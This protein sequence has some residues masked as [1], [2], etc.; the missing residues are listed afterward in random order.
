MIRRTLGGA[1]LLVLVV[2]G[3]GYLYLLSSLPQLDGRV[4][5]TGLAGEVRIARDT[6]GVPLIAAGGDEDA[7]FGLGFAHA[8]DRLFQMEM[9]RRYGAG[10]LAEIFGPRALGV[11]RQMRVLGLYRAAEAGLP[12]LAPAVQRRFEAYAAGVN[13][14][15]AARRAALPPEFLL[16]RFRPEPWRPADS[17]V[18]DKLM[19]LELAGNYRGEL[20]RAR[21]ARTLSPD[22]LAFLYPEYP[23]DAPT[24]LAELT[25]L[26]RQLP[27]DRLYA[28][29]PAIVGLHYASNNWVVD[30]AHSDSGKPILA[31]DPHLG[32]RAPSVWYLA[33]LEAPG[34]S[35]AGATL[36]GIPSVIIGHNDRIAWGLTSLEPDVQDLYLEET[37][38]KDGRRYLHAG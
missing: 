20:L 5:V 2:A 13:A 23:K 21:L 17:L 16:L 24:T 36:P 22:D 38:P 15:L 10:R 25:P 19:D 35:A 9:Q 12:L 32:L 4:V 7:A 14:F 6:D 29:L 18:W 1:L 8:Q 27:L 28:E 3:G 33:R 31:N 30:G 26:Y 37:D 34:L 11:D